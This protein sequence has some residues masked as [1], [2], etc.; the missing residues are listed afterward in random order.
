MIEKSA[1]Q[2]G[3]SKRTI[4]N[5]PCLYLAYMNPTVLV[6]KENREKKE[7]SLDE[8]NI[9]W[10][11]NKFYYSR[12]KHS[13]QSSYTMMLKEK[14]CDNLGKLFDSYPTFS[15]FRYYYR[16]HHSLQKEYISR[17]GLKH[18]QRNNR[19]LLGEG[20]I[21]FAPHIGVGL[22]DSTICDIYL[23]D[24]SGKLIGRP[25]LTACV[26]AYSGLCCGYTLSWE[27]GTYSLRG[28]MLNVIADKTEHCMKYGILIDKSDWDCNALP[29][30]IV[31]DK[32][33]EYIS[34]NFEQIAE[35]GV[36][37]INLT[38]YRPELKGRVEKFFDL[39]QGYY[40]P[41]LK[42]KGVIEPDYQERGA[43]D[44]RK[45]GYFDLSLPLFLPS[46]E[47]SLYFAVTMRQQTKSNDSCL[48]RYQGG[49]E[50]PPIR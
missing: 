47:S 35:L 5:Y 9:R 6:S 36:E 13:L 44:Y 31:T 42:G 2:N 19:P 49:R 45:D 21:E 33:S 10:A 8:K 22:L 40:K 25:I 4:S 46:L 16:K 15:Q 39:V 43:H 18:Y 38:A 29:S 30:T 11:L 26:D 32:G 17:N 7:L 23:V 20:V 3:V 14:Y 1:R 37:I 34:E 50:Y 24:D 41:H 27:G 48:R 28:L 12:S